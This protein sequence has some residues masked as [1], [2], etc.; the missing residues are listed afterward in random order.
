VVVVARHVTHADVAQE[1]VDSFKCGALP[2]GGGGVG[3]E[4]VVMLFLG[5]KACVRVSS[6]R[7]LALLMRSFI[8]LDAVLICVHCFVFRVRFSCSAPLCKYIW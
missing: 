3:L 1:Y 8:L 6:S 4:R 5:L 2:H 7:V